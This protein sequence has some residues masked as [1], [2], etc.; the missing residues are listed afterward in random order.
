MCFFCRNNID[1]K[2]FNEP[3]GKAGF[4]LIDFFYYN[5]IKS[6]VK[7]ELYKLNNNIYDDN[8]YEEVMDEVIPEGKNKRIFSC[9]HYF[10]S[11]CFRTNLLQ[12]IN[13]LNCPLCLK[14]MNILIP[15][16]NNFRNKY[17]F[18]KPEKMSKI[19]NKKSFI[20]FENVNDSKLFKEIILNFIKNY[21]SE[22]IKTVKEMTKKDY[23]Y[24]IGTIL[25]N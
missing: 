11:N 7:E 25:F 23:D 12:H 14:K 21:I 24:Y 5:S 9:G 8:L 13:N 18:L 20:K 15:P 6:C 16:L 1:L 22:Y 10:H 19:F 4:L 3:Y 2:S 17:S